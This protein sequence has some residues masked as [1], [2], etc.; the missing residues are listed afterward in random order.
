MSVKKVPQI[1]PSRANRPRSAF[2]LS[3]K[4][5]YTA[6]AGALL[7]VLSV[8]LMFHDHI[9]IQAQDFMRTMPMNS[10]AFISMR[11]VYEFFFVP[12]SQLWHQYDQFLTSMN[13][14]RS[15]VVSSAAGDIAL[16][17]VPN[18]KLSEMY[19]FVRERT[20][21]DIFG[22][23]QSN[24]SCRL[25]D[26]LGY[27]KPITSS[28]IPIP[29][30]YEGNVNLFRLLAY[31]K[32]Y[33]DYYRNSTYEAVD[34][35]SF[36]IDHKKGTFTPSADEFKKYLNLHY[37][38]AP[39]DFYTNLRPKPL[40]DFNSSSLSDALLVSDDSSVG[41]Y[42]AS[43][44]SAILNFTDPNAIS[45]SSIRSAFALDKLLSISMRA[46]KTYAEQ[47][48]AHFGV[49]VSEGR[50]GQVYYLGGFDSNVQVGDVTQTSGTTNPNVSEV[51][52]AKLAGYLGKIT[53]KGTGSGYGEIQFDAKEP[54]VLMCIYSVVPAMQYD[55]MRLDP[56]VAKQTRGD[57]FVPEFENLGMQPIIPAFVSLNRSKD[58]SYGWQ[59]RYSEYKTAFDINHGQFANGEP[60]SYW[61]IARA[62]GSDELN[63]FNIAALKINP[64]WLDSVFAV[65]YNGTEVTDCM[66][67]YAHFN[68]EKVSDM[69]EDG[70]PRV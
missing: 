60:L 7:P 49:T 31:N 8:D 53:G 67:G 20:D 33:S 19:K 46:G 38:N 2:D 65:N 17:S 47:I 66:F 34:V 26:L 69:T 13:D 12:Y 15:S 36:N 4:H 44:N 3:Q 27:G 5:L 6:P 14:Y 21:K 10:A 41:P 42:T 51:G 11:G 25:L 68:I 28:K 56:F 55:C 61:S 58:K 24:N 1:K 48:E 45:V 16:S 22:Y 9:R 57:Y 54:G 63:T 18:V 64:H 52:N 23:P 30:L 62:R 70:M 40:F 43:G 32:I 29:L 35:Y 37:R 50:D 59:P 39:L